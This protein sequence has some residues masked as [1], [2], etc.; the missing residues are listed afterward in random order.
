MIRSLIKKRKKDPLEYADYL[1]REQHIKNLE[2]KGFVL[3][4]RRKAKI[5]AYSLV[6]LGIITLPL[7]CGSVFLIILGL[8]LLGFSIPELKEFLRKKYKQK[9]YKL[10][11]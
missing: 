11:C 3:I 8:S 7:P 5:L 9:R 10:K 4:T 6:F 1:K 2:S